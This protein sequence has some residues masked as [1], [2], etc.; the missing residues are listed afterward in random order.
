[1]HSTT[2]HDLSNAAHIC[3]ESQILHA[4]AGIVRRQISD[5]TILN[6]QCPAP[7]EVSISNSGAKLP[8]S[9]NIFMCWLLDDSAFDSANDSTSVPIGKLRKCLSLAECIVSVNKNKFTSFH[10]GLA[11]QMI[12]FFVCSTFHRCSTQ[13]SCGYTG[14][15]YLVVMMVGDISQFTICVARYLISHVRFYPL[16]TLLLD[17]TLP[18]LFSEL[19]KNMLTKS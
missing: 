3:D 14:G 7:E 15:L 10:L 11:L 13:K 19:G 8:S 18:L 1:M 17:V 5:I 6:D 16:F 2:V 12:W 9:L 4:A